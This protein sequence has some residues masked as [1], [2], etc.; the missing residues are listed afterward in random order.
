MS[1]ISIAR[2][3]LACRLLAVLLPCLPAQAQQASPAVHQPAQTFDAA[4]ATIPVPG[5]PYAAT[6]SEDSSGSVGG[7][8]LAQG[9]VQEVQ[10]VIEVAHVRKQAEVAQLWRQW[11]Q[12]WPQ[13]MDGR[14]LLARAVSGRLLVYVG[15]FD[16]I[17][18]GQDWC[19]QMQARVALCQIWPA[20]AIGQRETRLR[21]STELGKENE[22]G[23]D[24]AAP[25]VVAPPAPHPGMQSHL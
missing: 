16:S 9:R 11:R 23:R 21:L 3:S 25:D 24:A 13:L 15:N 17:E 1:L 14:Q 2:L 7:Q 4:P 5:T 6:D 20:Q 19:E 8:G 12:E 18:D 10:W 22:A